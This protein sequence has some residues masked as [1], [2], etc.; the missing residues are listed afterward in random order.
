M[1]MNI[2]SRLKCD[3]ETLKGKVDDYFRTGHQEKHPS[4]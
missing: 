2:F 1:K 4:I 3:F